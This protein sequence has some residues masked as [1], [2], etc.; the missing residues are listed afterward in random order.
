M[1]TERKAAARHPNV[2][3]LYIK[4]VTV[5][6][7][8]PIAILLAWRILC[9]LRFLLFQDETNNMHP[10]IA[11]ADRFSGEIIGAAIEEQRIMG[12]GLLESIY[13]RCCLRKLKLHESSRRVLP[14]ANNP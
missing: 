12:P 14:D 4:R 1:R 7:V 5:P 10:R 13:E 8:K 3:T 6:V 2:R 9:F 11:K